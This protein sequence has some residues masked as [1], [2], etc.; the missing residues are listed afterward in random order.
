MKNALNV[1][2]LFVLVWNISSSDAK[3]AI[4]NKFQSQI[5]KSVLIMNVK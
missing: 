3:I 2:L 4:F 1:L 5:K